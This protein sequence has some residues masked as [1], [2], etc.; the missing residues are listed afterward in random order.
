MRRNPDYTCSVCGATFPS[1]S[2][3]KSHAYKEH[4]VYVTAG[5]APTSV[6][7]SGPR[8]KCSTC[9]EAFYTK[10]ELLKHMDQYARRSAANATHEYLAEVARRQA[11]YE[12]AQEELMRRQRAAAVQERSLSTQRAPQS[13]G[14]KSANDIVVL[15]TLA[16]LAG[17]LMLA[18]DRKKAKKK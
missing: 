8:W 6:L 4:E 17:G 3:L 15:A 14:D 1:R 13:T 7:Y 9:G 10:A 11:A 18:N 12:R 5:K 16:M 2:Q